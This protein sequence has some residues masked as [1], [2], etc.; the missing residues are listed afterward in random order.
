MGNAPVRRLDKPL[1]YRMAMRWYKKLRYWGPAVSG[2][3]SH[4][5]PWTRI[6]KKTWGKRKKKKNHNG[7]NDPRKEKERKKDRGSGRV[8]K[9]TDKKS[10]KDL[11]SSGKKA[12][13]WTCVEKQEKQKRSLHT[14]RLFFKQ[15]EKEKKRKTYKGKEP[16]YHA[17]PIQSLHSATKNCFLIRKEF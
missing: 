9:Q 12:R 14:K 17:L 6:K 11:V 7:K 13:K 3:L 15:R 16:S 8:R 2:I 1:D 5:A 4:L 10:P